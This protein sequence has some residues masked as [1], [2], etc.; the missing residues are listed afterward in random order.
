MIRLTPRLRKILKKPLGKIYRKVGKYKGKIIAVGD[1]A[2]YELIR[3]G[4]VPTLIIYDNKVKRKPTSK[5]IKRLLDSIRCDTYKIR[6]PRSTIQEDAWIVI[7]EGL[8]RKSKIIVSG[9]EDLL[10]LPAVLLAK[11]GSLIFYGQP[12][13]G[14]VLIKVNAKKKR[15]IKKLVDEM[16]VKL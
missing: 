8:R 4:T 15:E 1:I 10:V 12:N 13:R 14:M 2:A 5:K 9:E 6:N 16:E 3:G 7:E 11:N